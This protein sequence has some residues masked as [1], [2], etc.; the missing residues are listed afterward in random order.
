[1]EVEAV[2]V[3]HVDAVERGDLAADRLVRARLG[4]GVDGSL[5]C[6]PSAATTI[7]RCPARTSAASSDATICSAPPTVSSETALKG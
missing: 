6:D 5:G 4:R 7:D 2:E 1:V 3:D